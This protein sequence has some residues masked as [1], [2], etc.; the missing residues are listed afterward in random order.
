M[1][2]STRLLGKSEMHELFPDCRILT[3]R[4]LWIIPKSYIAIRTQT[5]SHTIH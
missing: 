5:D 4:M 3:E 2:S 1:V